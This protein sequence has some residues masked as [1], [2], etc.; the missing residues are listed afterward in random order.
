MPD[1]ITH[2]AEL[3][4]IVLCYDDITVKC[5]FF[6]TFLNLRNALPSTLVLF[7]EEFAEEGW[8]HC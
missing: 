6:D 3:E 4:A 5:V 1:L 7:A 8:V 2:I